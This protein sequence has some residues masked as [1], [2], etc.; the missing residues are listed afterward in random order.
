MH[1]MV[2]SKPAAPSNGATPTPDELPR[3]SQRE[4]LFTMAGVLLV[5]LLAAL[6]QTIV[7]TALPRMIADLMTRTRRRFSC[8]KTC[9]LV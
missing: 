4:T 6:D 8:T 3:F 7:A 9:Q 1:T 5:M 2:G